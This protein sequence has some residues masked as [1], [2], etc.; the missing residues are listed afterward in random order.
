MDGGGLLLAFQQQESERAAAAAAALTLGPCEHV[1]AGEA[2]SHAR[3]QCRTCYDRMRYYKSGERLSTFSLPNTKRESTG[4]DS[5]LS[6][7]LAISSSALE[8]YELPSP[9]PE[10]VLA[11][12]SPL[13]SSPEPVGD[14]DSP[15]RTTADS[16]APKRKRVGLSPDQQ[17]QTQLKQEKR[18]KRRKKLEDTVKS[19]KDKKKSLSDEVTQLLKSVEELE[20]KRAELILVCS[21]L[22][23]RLA[24]AMRAVVAEG[25]L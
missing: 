17:D 1:K 25:H 6:G 10:A 20:T 16:F 15:L 24:P 5:A 14:Y 12:T 21:S 2:K 13:D 9:S 7:L 11:P 4:V 8:A 3:K 19:L 23:Q 22:E 18:K